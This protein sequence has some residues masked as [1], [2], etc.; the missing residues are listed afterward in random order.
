M[1]VAPLETYSLI[2]HPDTPPERVSAV[3]VDVTLD[4]GD[5]I[6]LDFRVQGRERLLLPPWRQSRRADRLWETTCFELFVR[7][8]EGAGYFEFN[9]SPSTEWAAYRFTGHREGME[10]LALDMEPF[11]GLQG[12]GGPDLLHVDLDLGFFPN[13]AGRMGISAIIEEAGGRRSYWALAH[14]PG[15]PDFHH[16]DCFRLELPP[17][18]I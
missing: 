16:L 12:E 1:E 6:L 9:F 18:P 10:P 15:E 4:V 13:V 3:E 5:D 17:A 2:P 11:V 14:G 7:P 8:I